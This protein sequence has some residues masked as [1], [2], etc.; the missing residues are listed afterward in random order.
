MLQGAEPE[1]GPQ[2]LG[3]AQKI[4]TESQ[5]LDMSSLYCWSVVLLCSDCDCALVLP[6]SGHVH[7]LHPLGWLYQSVSTGCRSSAVLRM[8]LEKKQTNKKHSSRPCQPSKL[9]KFLHI[10]FFSFVRE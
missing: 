7:T 2:P 1:K 5:T 6:S 3:G 8:G 4:V 9:G 10:F